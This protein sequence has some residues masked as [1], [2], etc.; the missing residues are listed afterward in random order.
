[1]AL[2]VE[3]TF[4]ILGG[5][6]IIGYL[7]ELFSKKFAVPSALLL[8]IIGYALKLSGYVELG[9]LNGIQDFFGSLALIVLLFD[10]GLSINI[11]EILFKSGRMLLN[12]LLTMGLG[13]IGTTILFTALGLDP[14]LGAI[15][16]AIV[17]GIGST[18]TISILR[19]LSL[20][21]SVK[22]F[23][24]LESSITD[25]FAIIFTIV[26][27]Q[28]VISGNIDVQTICQGIAGKFAVG[29]IFGIVVGVLT[30]A[31]SSKIEKGYNYMV[32][33]AI[34][35]MLFAITEF[36]GGSGAIS[37]LIF[38]IALGNETTV[39]KILHLESKNK[40]QIVKE[41][42]VEVSFFIRT[43]FFVFLGAIVTIGGIDNFVIACAIMALLYVIRYVSIKISTAKSQLVGYG[44][45]LTV[46]CPRGLATAVLATY[47][48][49]II[50]GA[51]N[52]G[53]NGL[54]EAL[55]DA[56]MIPEI[57]FYIIV[58]SIVITTIAVPFVMKKNMAVKENSS[59]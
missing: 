26:L 17:G 16:G 48:L 39:R 10:G 37:A 59:K 30:I 58:L 44:R 43:F 23:L 1:M 36:L 6:I 27:T 12:S 34:V 49:A 54:V 25:V 35:L 5:I 52:N 45:I 24:T 47:P 56:K 18:T 31:F 55:A 28:A 14:L 19:G 32:T 15:T 50:Q 33:L 9:S 8:L 4:L 29:I 20:P 46:I 13:V 7:G 51:I 11:Y 22:N 57:S 41:L 3:G 38:G 2:S 40:K 53:N 42:Q 21:S